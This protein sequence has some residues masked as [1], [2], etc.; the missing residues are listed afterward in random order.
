MRYT[1]PKIQARRASRTGIVSHALVYVEARIRG[2]RTLAP[3]GLW[4][5]DDHEDFTIGGQRRTYYASSVLDV[6]P[7]RT[8]IGLSV[9]RLRL[10]LSS[11][12]AAVEQLIRGY[13]VKGARV[14]IHRA[15]YDDDGNLIAAPERIFKGWVNGAPIVVGAIENSD[16]MMITPGSASLECVSNTRMLTIHGSRTKSHEIQRQRQGD[17]FRRYATASASA[18]VYWGSHAPATAPT[19]S[20]AVE[21]ARQK[22]RNSER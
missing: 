21:R 7:I 1:D 15:E 4:T 8:E 3:L 19:I 2:T 18:T 6:P 17:E 11:V 13:D 9:N 14:Q 22:Q 20:A 5:G 12:S 16:G 10:G